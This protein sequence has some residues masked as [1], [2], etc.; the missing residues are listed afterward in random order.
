[1]PTSASSLIYIF[2][3]NMPEAVPFIAM[4][5]SRGLI[6]LA[7]TVMQVL[8]IDLGTDMVPAI[9]LGAE[10]PEPGIMER[11][12]RSQTEP[13]LNWPAPGQGALVVWHD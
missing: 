13:L 2:T 4:L 3:S 7:L 6:P 1:M 10:P 8:S 12:P 5:F 11:P 9:G